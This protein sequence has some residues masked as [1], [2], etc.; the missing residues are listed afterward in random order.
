MDIQAAAFGHSK[1]DHDTTG[2]GRVNSLKEIRTG[3]VG[4]GAPVRD[5]EEIE[6]RLPDLLVVVDD[7]N[8]RFGG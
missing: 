4:R 5:H 1:V 7:V 6:Q 8:D 3:G 2:R